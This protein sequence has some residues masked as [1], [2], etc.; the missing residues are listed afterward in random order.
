MADYEI[1]GPYLIAM[2]MGMG[3]LCIFIWG[4]FSGAFHNSDSAAIQFFQAEMD[5][6]RTRAHIDEN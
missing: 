6:D 5:N 1:F 3:A 2:M 4:V